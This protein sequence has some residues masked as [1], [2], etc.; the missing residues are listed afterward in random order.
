MRLTLNRHMLQRLQPHAHPPKRFEEGEPKGPDGQGQ[1]LAAASA[2]AAFP[3]A[4]AGDP[5]VAMRKAMKAFH[6]WPRVPP[7]EEAALAAQSRVA[8]LLGPAGS[9]PEQQTLVKAA[10]RWV[11]KLEAC[12]DHVTVGE[13]L[14]IPW[15]AEAEGCTLPPPPAPGLTGAE[16]RELHRICKAAAE[17]YCNRCDM[18]LSATL[19]AAATPAR[20]AAPPAAQGAGPAHACSCYKGARVKAGLGRVPAR[21]AH[22]SS[23]PRPA[24]S[25][26]RPFTR[27]PRCWSCFLLLGHPWLPATTRRRR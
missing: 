16:A 26:L 22:S 2:L 17:A 27:T 1:R 19:Q 24:R 20:Q 7:E 5:A 9:E 6:A 4:G 18:G 3:A 11:I 8:A 25:S 21:D 10:A 23:P 13:R 14:L 15:G 12:A